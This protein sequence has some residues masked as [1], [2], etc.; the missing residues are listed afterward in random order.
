MSAVD[1]LHCGFTWDGDA[2]PLLVGTD[3]GHRW[4]YAGAVPSEGTTLP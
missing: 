4:S 3:H 1:G 2:I